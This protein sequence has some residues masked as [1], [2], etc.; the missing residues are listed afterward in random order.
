MKQRAVAK[1]GV[2]RTLPDG[3]T[4]RSW[5]QYI[6]AWRAFGA[7][8]CASL[9]PNWVTVAYDPD[10]LV[11][12]GRKRLDVP[13]VVARALAAKGRDV[14]DRSTV[15]ETLKAMA[16]EAKRRAATESFPHRAISD[17]EAAVL[18]RAAET[19]EHDAPTLSKA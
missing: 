12:D 1:R 19:F 11:T 8:V 14:L 4:T 16:R 9:G 5:K 6:A 7:D 18:W 13:I 15:V 3:T 2:A 17:W 10:L